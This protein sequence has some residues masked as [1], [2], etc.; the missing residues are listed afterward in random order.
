[1]QVFAKVNDNKTI[2]LEVTGD[3]TV[4]ALVT[5]ALNKKY[6]GMAIPSDECILVRYLNRELVLNATLASC[7]L[8]EETTFSILLRP[9]QNSLIDN[10]VLRDLQRFLHVAAAETTP[11]EI[12]FIGVGSYDHGHHDPESIT[13][14]QC[15]SAL[16][17][18][19]LE[20]RVDL[21]IILIDPGFKTDSVIPPQVYHSGEWALLHEELGGK[22]RQYKHTTAVTRRA[23]DIWLT[24]F[25]TGIA[26]YGSNLK[27]VATINL[28]T[29]FAAVTSYSG[30]CLICGNFYASPTDKSQ[31]FTLGDD[32]TIVATG[33][34]VN[35]PH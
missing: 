31:F 10:E 20:N 19:C 12:T 28:P 23:C 25:A 22:I 5:Q 27:V 13:R 29:L 21:N 2:M 17:E 3:Q 24:T 4:K 15:P 6:P 30:T 14:Q 11:N 26:E 9:A 18:H 35:P 33:F 8:Q 7:N 1:M 34:E 16:L 32:Q